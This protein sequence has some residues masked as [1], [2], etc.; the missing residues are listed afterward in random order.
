MKIQAESKLFHACYIWVICL[1]GIANTATAQTSNV[2]LDLQ[3]SPT[4]N[5]AQVINVSDLIN[6]EGGA[7]NIYSLV[8]QNQSSE[9][10]ENLFL[11]FTFASAED[12]MLVE[13]FQAQGQPF[14]LAPGEQIASLNSNL[15]RQLA[16][17]GGF[18]EFGGG[19][20]AAGEQFSNDLSSLSRLPQG[21]YTLTVNL[22]QGANG[23][24]GGELIASAQATLGSNITENVRDIYLTAP[25]DVLGAGAQIYNPYPEY[26]W[27]GLAGTTYRL[28]VVEAQDQQS[29]ESLLQSAFST[30][31]YLGDRSLLSNSES[32]TILDF[33]IIDARLE[34]ASF[35]TPT[36][37]VQPLEE[38]KQ[39]Y[40]Q[41]FTELRSSSNREARPSE[42][43]SFKL[44]GSQ[45]EL[46]LN[47][48]S[49][50]AVVL[51]KL[52]GEEKYREL[53]Q[54]NVRLLSI[55]LEGETLTGQAALD[56]LK[57]LAGKLN[58]DEISVLIDE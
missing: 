14:H 25:G 51:Q 34:S 19:L 4:L 39:Y 46:T 57:E 13:T 3:V 17:E 49:E 24:S 30:A 21:Q 58:A 6:P 31:P 20:T 55:Q 11:G 56:K 12:G 53:R 43:W 10:V 40:W 15:P 44:S 2:F 47:A 41:I 26:R 23:P 38:G 18:I 32:G 7:Q 52:V 48:D 27:D 33:E 22:Y 29:P 5:N 42:I 45:S 54:G 8:I 50:L 35:Q 36:V 1:L 28:I 37:N 16:D 9:S